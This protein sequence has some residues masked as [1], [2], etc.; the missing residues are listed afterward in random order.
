M[1][2]L[3]EEDVGVYRGLEYARYGEEALQ[4]DLYVPADVHDEVPCIVAI[5]GGGFRPASKER[6]ARPAARLA[7][8]GFAAACIEYRGAPRDPFPA[9]V[10]DTKAAVRF[11]RAHANRYGIDGGRIGAFGQSA[12]G[13]LAV[14]LGVTGGVG[15]LEGDGGN[16]GV[17]SRI[18]AAVSFA[19]VFN[20]ISRL[21]EGG[22]QKANLETKRETNGLWVGEPFSPTSDRWREASPYFYVS[23][24]DPPVLFVHCKPDNV[25]PY[26]QSK[27]M[28]EAMKSLSMGHRFVL[29]D[30]GGHNVRGHPAIGPGAWGEAVAFFRQNLR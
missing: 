29:Y 11:I 25:V 10:Y 12:G 15:E 8:E 7:R 16:P 26:E 13:H 24:D 18:Q 4:L 1:Q 23:E 2:T 27:E 20:F 17:S 28:Y 3:D 14:M 6:F 30:D 19:G 9:A 5:A 22:H 21:K